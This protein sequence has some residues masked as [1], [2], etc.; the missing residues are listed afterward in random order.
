MEPPS[1]P[2]SF[3]PP[4]P[5]GSARTGFRKRA[6]R[7]AR[8]SWRGGGPRSAFGAGPRRAFGAARRCS[9][10]AA[11]RCSR[12]G[13][14][15]FS[16]N[17]RSG[18]FCGGR[19]SKDAPALPSHQAPCSTEDPRFLVGS[20]LIDRSRAAVQSCRTECPTTDSLATRRSSPRGSSRLHQLGALGFRPN[21]RSSHFPRSRLSKN[22]PPSQTPRSASADFPRSLVD[23]RAAIIP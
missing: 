10:G 14:P 19:F 15:E 2:P 1:F 11:R 6:G 5:S 8:C 18:S 16:S 3:P 21:S 20:R 22:A 13:A 17:A 12:D 23:S 7:R 9:F 4:C